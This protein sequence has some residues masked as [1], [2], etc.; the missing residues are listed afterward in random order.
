[1]R[2]SGVAIHAITAETG[3]VEALKTRLAN[4]HLVDLPFPLHSDPDAKLCAKP[5]DGY[6]LTEW[7]DAGARL[8][9]DYVGVSYTMVQPALEIVDK[10]GAVIQKWSWHSIQPPPVPM[11]VGPGG[12]KAI[13]GDG[14]AI[15][16]VMARPMSADILPAIKEGRDLK[17]SAST[18]VAA[19]VCSMC[20]ERCTIS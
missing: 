20:K 18:T 14:T 19:V 3:G 8:K 7:F 11:K 9:G 10:T 4:R 2:E 13:I 17:L 12:G 15:P 6:Y 1:M 5:G 16:L